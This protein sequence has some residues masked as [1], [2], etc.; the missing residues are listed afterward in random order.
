MT[1]EAR[2]R[3]S[4]GIDFRAIESPIGLNWYDADPNLQMLVER[5]C[6]PADRDFAQ[7]QLRRMGAVIGGPV[8][9]RAEITD[10]NPP[11]LEKYDRAGNEVNTV[12]HHQS[13]LDTKRDLWEHGFLG[14]RWSEEV[15]NR[16]SGRLPAVVNTGF[17]YLLNQAETGMACGI[18]MTSSAAGIIS[19][20]APPELREQFLP[21]LITTD[22][23]DAWDGAMFMTEVRG[24][25]DLAS[26]ECTATKS[27]D[28]SWRLNG[29]KWFCSNL[30][31]Q[32]ILVLA[33][34]EGS[35]PGLASLA[36]FLVPR[37]RRDG[38][39]NGI[40][41]RRLKDKLGTKA[42][43]TGEVDFVDAEAYLMG[44][45]AGSQLAEARDPATDRGGRGINRMMEMVQ[46]S[47]FGVAIMGLGIM[48]R[49]FMEAACYS[50]HREAFGRLLIEFPLVRETLVNMAVEVDAG[51]ALAFEAAEAGARHDDDGRRLYRI[52]VPLAKYRC[53]RRGVDLALQAVEIHGGNG[54]IENWPVARQLRD[55]VCHPIW[56]GTE[57]IICLDVLRAMA[58]E[59][60]DEALFARI[61]RALGGAEHPALADTLAT[62]GRAID[63]VKD[64]IEYVHRAPED[65]RLLNARRLTD[66]MA[67]VTQAALLVEEAVWELANRGSGRK[68][69]VAR[70]FV[71]MRLAQHAMRGIGSENRIPLDHFGDIVEYRSVPPTGAKP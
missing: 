4:S 44:R 57:N 55:A 41:I 65:L 51:C 15:R 10:K 42:V 50:H 56:E 66:Y 70:Q 30:D 14:L 25:S 7:G 60:A 62:V 28:G 67:D 49:S 35:S 58:K 12:E 6:A 3:A 59:Q 36:M 69:I 17:L 38:T 52:L 40:H 19:K 21:H 61:E 53:A 43:P 2:A 9:A 29:A 1:T 24:G 47:R 34:P 5:L 22:Y 16:P 18:G 33:R 8:A 45:E 63:D 48:R 20:H 39:R 31:A 27:G 46:S 64:A 54:Y 23:A 71:E 37:E 11:R 13:A 26:S 32:A 68:A